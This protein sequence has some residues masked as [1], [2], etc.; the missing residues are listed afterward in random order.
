[1]TGA[2]YSCCGNIP[3]SVYSFLYIDNKLLPDPYYRDN[4][5]SGRLGVYFNDEIVGYNRVIEGTSFL[6]VDSIKEKEEFETED[7]NVEFIVN[8]CILFI[9]STGINP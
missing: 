5:L 1:M 7:C 8:F 4:E 6:T 9:S 3:G 2:G